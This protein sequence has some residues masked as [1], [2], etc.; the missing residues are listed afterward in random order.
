[1]AK[2][3]DR[4]G[5]YCRNPGEREVTWP[6]VGMVVENQKMLTRESCTHT[7]III[8]G[9]R[10]SEVWRLYTPHCFGTGSLS[11]ANS[12]NEGL[13]VRGLTLLSD[14]SLPSG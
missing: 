4:G 8:I 13:A 3:G 9:G 1:M 12:F 7:I 5:G 11:E 10:N 2:Q 14:T 6:M